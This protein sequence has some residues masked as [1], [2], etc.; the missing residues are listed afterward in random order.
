MKS[1][2]DFH[3]KHT[4]VCLFGFLLPT[5]QSN[6]TKHSQ[7][8]VR[9]HLTLCFKAIMQCPFRATN[10]RKHA[11]A[12]LKNLEAC[13]KH[14]VSVPRTHTHTHIHTHTHTHTRKHT[15]N[16]KNTHTRKHTHTHT[17]THTHKHTY[18]HTNIHTHTQTY[19]HTHTHTSIHT[20]TQ[21]YT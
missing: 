15:H 21:A 1:L 10:R 17:H 2:K 9:I 13:R 16:N 3:G 18:T 20:H 14:Y 4:V 7:S 6:L 12:T 8:K 19:S 11:T 5:H